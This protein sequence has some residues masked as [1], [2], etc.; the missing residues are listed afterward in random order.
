MNFKAIGFDYGGVIAGIPGPEFE[1]MVISLLG[2]EL[3][4]FQDV[5]FEFNHL[6]NNNVLSPEDFWKKVTEEL[7][8]S[9]KH[10]DLM[11][12]IKELPHH[13]INE[14]VLDLVDKLRASGYKTGLL[15]N[16][17]MVAANRFREAGLVNHFDTVVVS[18][19]IGYSKPHPKAF[20][21][22]IERLGVMAVE[23]IF[24]DDTEKSL[25]VAKEIGFHPVLFT[26]YGSLLHTLES[27]GIKI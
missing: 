18:A 10:G 15:S 14:Q 20:E 2:V 13:E 23:L 5:Y 7:G 26:S 24:I 6:M 9:D 8:V 16:N 11:K 17:T 19:E 1:K 25:T 27:I 21:I 4:T 12:F 22:F 3:R